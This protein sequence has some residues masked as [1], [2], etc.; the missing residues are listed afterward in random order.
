VDV[1]TDAEM[2]EVALAEAR[3]GLAEG[4]IPIGAAVFDGD[5]R[6][7]GSLGTT[8]GYRRA[9]RARM[10][11]RTRFGAPDGSGAIAG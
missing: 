1:V 3:A 10:G 8:G 7:V 5:G 4:G 9:I 2:L 11:R 6:L